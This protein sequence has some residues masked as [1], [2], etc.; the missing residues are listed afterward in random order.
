MFGLGVTELLILL[1][2]V[3]LVIGL[4]IAIALI[5]IV[6]LRKP[7]SVPNSEPPSDASSATIASLREEN[8]RLREELAGLRATSQSR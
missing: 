8:Q 6:L 2:V 1:F 3:A 5:L 4:P 7:N